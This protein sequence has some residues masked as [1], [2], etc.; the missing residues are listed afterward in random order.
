MF[1]GSSGSFP[2]APSSQLWLEEVETNALWWVHHI[3]PPLT[4]CE[5]KIWNNKTLHLRCQS[6]Q[7]WTIVRTTWLWNS[8]SREMKLALWSLLD[9][10]PKR[11]QN[12]RR[13]KKGI[14][15]FLTKCVFLHINKHCK[16]NIS[17]NLAVHCRGAKRHGWFKCSEN[18]N[19]FSLFGCKCQKLGKLRVIWEG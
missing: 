11:E 4:L 6:R 1:S 18:G 2:A 19:T 8:T 16:S 7:H 10:V 9:F 15:S 17:A 3:S 12:Y 14:I 5:K 13:A